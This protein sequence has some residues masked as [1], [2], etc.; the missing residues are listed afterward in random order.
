MIDSPVLPFVFG[1]PLH[2]ER[3]TLRL[4]TPADT[5]DVYAYQSREDVCRY[6]LFDPRTRDE[7]AT[8]VAEHSRATTLE[9][10]G[11]YLQL[12]VE[13]AATGDVPGRVIGDSYFTIT[14]VENSHGEIG[15]TLHPDFAGHGYAREAAAAVLAIAFEQIGLHRVHAELDPRNHSSVAL[16]KRLG[17]REEAFFV[18]DMYFKGGWAD[19]GVYGILR[20]EW[21]GV[22]S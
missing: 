1:E 11:D 7:V 20:K 8:K 18:E 17:M 4:M 6:L 15:W 16:C 21:V 13:L 12:A 10:D 14:S 2:T 3:L 9:M 19:T 5:D 22:N